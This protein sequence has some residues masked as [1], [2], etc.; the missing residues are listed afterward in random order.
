MNDK[1][2]EANYYSALSYLKMNLKEEAMDCFERAYSQIP[3]GHKREDNVVYFQILSRLVVFHLET[4]HPEQ[5][6]QFVEEGLGIKR[7]YPDLLFL[8]AV[9]LVDDQKYDEMLEAII[10]YLLTISDIQMDHSDYLYVNEVALD[11]VYNNLIPMAYRS[12]LNSRPIREIVEKL[13]NKTQSQWLTRAHT[14]M[15]Q[16]DEVKVPQEN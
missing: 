3:E 13:S 1:S 15:L 7:D 2:Y 6:K 5:S 11:E 12:A 16:M 10:L 8:K 14:I 4:S 9:L